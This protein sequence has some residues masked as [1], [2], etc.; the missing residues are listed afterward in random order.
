MSERHSANIN[1]G[2][3]IWARETSGLSVADIAEKVGVKPERYA[4]WE[5]GETTPTMNQLRDIGRVYKRP[6]ALFYSSSAPREMT[7]VADYRLLPEHVT[8]GS[9][10]LSFEIRRAHERRETAL[11]LSL[12]SSDPIAS[13][14]LDGSTSDD[15]NIL[16][17]RIRDTLKVSTESQRR[18]EGD[19]YLALRE[20]I[21]AV[22]RLG[23]LV[24]QASGI[25]IQ[26]MRGFSLAERP[27]PVIVLN[28]SDS[29]RGR[30]FT[31]MHEL[32]HVVLGDGGLCNLREGRGI[33]PI[34]VFCNR[35]AG[36]VL[37]PASV[38]LCQPVVQQ[39]GTDPQWHDVEVRNLSNRFVVSK[40]VILRRLLILGRTSRE[41]YSTMREEY[42]KYASPRKDS[43]GGP[44]R[45]ILILR[46]N[47]VA[48]TSMVI[49]A[50]RDDHI[51][52]SLLSRY[53]GGINLKH[54]EPLE[55][56]LLRRGGADA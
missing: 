9:P 1:P 48:Y 11:D 28:G 54:I 26:M 47:G 25:D 45:H 33:N 35:V 43:D 5:S 30:I 32:I 27:L 34:E 53:L 10:R 56:A 16:A 39:H 55:E 42:S 49:G 21:S 46:D 2:M 20:W 50:Y 24:F 15:P 29:V 51:T 23:I 8:N 13:F 17:E 52:E 4:E 14:Q 40:E 22:E 44:Q 19:E 7:L 36:S 37:V 41:F 31:L 3:L 38:L 6:S 12:L 18:W